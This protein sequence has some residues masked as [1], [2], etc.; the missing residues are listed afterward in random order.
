MSEKVYESCTIQPNLLL[1]FKI[2]LDINAT[3]RIRNTF[4]FLCHNTKTSFLLLR[5][6]MKLNE[7]NYFI[8]AKSKTK[9]RT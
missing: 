3:F 2:N 4:E 5:N 7:E 9:E 1:G 8:Q 6:L